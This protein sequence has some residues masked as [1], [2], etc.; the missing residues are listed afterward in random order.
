MPNS[1]HLGTR[2]IAPPIPIIAPI[3][4]AKKADL[5]NMYISSAVYFFSA[6]IEG[7]NYCSIF[8][9]ARMP[10]MITLTRKKEITSTQRLHS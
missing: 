4:P 10:E 3:S 8:S 6:E 1:S 2:I 7:F 9:S 5:A